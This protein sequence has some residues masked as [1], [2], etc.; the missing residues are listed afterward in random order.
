MC[1]PIPSPAPAAPRGATK[2]D[3]MA[4]LA[5]LLQAQ[6]EALFRHAPPAGAG[7][8]P[9][10]LH[11]TR[12]AIR[13]LRV[14]LR[15]FRKRLK[16]TCARQ[17]D[18]DLQRLNRALGR[19]RDAD[20]WLARLQDDAWPAR[21]VQTHSWQEL[22]ARHRTR[23]RRQQATLRRL[24]GPAA[25]A[26]LRRRLRRLMTRDL[27]RAARQA[28]PRTF[29]EGARRAL[30]R[31]V[32]QARKTAAAGPG[33]ALADQHRLRIAL[34]RL[35]Y[36]AAFFAPLLGPEVARLQRRSHAADR[37][38]G[39]LRDAALA[40]ELLAQTPPPTPRRLR[41]HLR[42]AQ[43]Q[44]D[45]QWAKA[46]RDWRAPAFQQRVKRALRR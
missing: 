1:P 4:G 8:D 37:A 41:A 10:A 38:L 26:A 5:R 34:R 7:H 13:R 6:I 29:A 16:P 28:R 17:L 39:E 3:L 21:L 19:V 25:L 44:A 46:W 9:E 40:L 18:R 32:R 12:I 45:R 30:R 14:L 2:L 31:H 23:R 24:L 11:Q 20:V 22:L 33:P 35:R 42:A 15:A 27:P 43:Q 36:L